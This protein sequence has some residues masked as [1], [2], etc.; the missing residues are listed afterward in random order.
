M[1]YGTQ[2]FAEKL[3][4]IIKDD[5]RHPLYH[6]ACA[7]AEAMSVHIYGD[8]PEMILKRVRPRE[9]EEVQMYRL[10]NYEP[11]TKAGADKAIEI[12]S[13]IFNPTLY[14]IV[15]PKDQSEDIKK[16]HDYMLVEYP[17]YNSV[18]NF[19]KD[20]LLRKMIADP[21]GVI[22][23][24]PEHFPEND[25]EMI[26]PIS[27]IYS[28]QNVY[29]Y[30]RD[31]FLIFL[32]SER[33]ETQDYFYFS[34]YDK[35]QY[36]NFK[37]WWIEAYKE[38]NFEEVEKP[39]K[40]NFGEIPAWFLRGKSKATGNGSIL[41]E[42]YFSS[43]LPH[44]NLAVIHES[45]LLG[46]YITHMHPQRAILTEECNHQ[47]EWEGI[48]LKCIHGFMQ[49]IGGAKTK[50]SGSACPKCTGTG[51]VSVK[52]PYGEWQFSR[53]KLEEGLPTGLKPVEYINIPTEATK[54]LEER[55][56]EM[57]NLAMWS[58]NMD[59]E[60]EVGENQSGVAKAIDRSAQS[61]TLYNIGATVFDVHLTNQLYFTNKYMFKVRSESENKTDE[62][63]LPDVVKPTQF[64]ILTTAELLNNFNV[65]AKAGVDKNYL[66]V[67]Q[68]DI[69][70]KD[71]NNSPEMKKYLL[72]MLM[73]DPLFG[74]VQ[75]EIMTGVN[76]G[77]IKKVDWAIHE[78]LKSFVDRAIQ[79]DKTF[80]DHDLEEKVLKMN[81]Y[82]E[83]LV[84]ANKPMQVDPKSLQIGNAA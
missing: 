39:Y 44:W 46:A 10:E 52:S 13:K 72:T 26:E 61:D 5:L 2:E 81:Q 11:T 37:C 17:E 12:V 31:C 51:Q 76:S 22:A 14:S 33:I 83:E 23:I 80:L 77:V 54:M 59:V 56:R 19:D 71:L 18:T 53:K 40:H 1:I 8:K 63:N 60:D 38:M 16:L 67:K 27:V 75:N 28:S 79:E 9:D 29:W 64:D 20:V 41:Y 43:A 55:T 4:G 57:N 50:M 82:G 25:I 66:R 35:N 30:D 42:S 49:G 47:F 32:Y 21:N 48:Q 68:M 84:K 36:I 7:H 45:D 24:R 74:Y 73:I 62:K 69:V 58:I 3:K 78:N 6:E 15:W 34:Y 65:A 70:A